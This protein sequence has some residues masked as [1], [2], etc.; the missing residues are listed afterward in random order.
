MKKLRF[1]MVM[2][3]EMCMFGMRMFLR[4]ALSDKFSVTS[5]AV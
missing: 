1:A 2:M 3:M 4:A 5:C